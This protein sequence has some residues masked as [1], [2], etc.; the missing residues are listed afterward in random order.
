[1]GLANVD[2]AFVTEAG[3]IAA[4][5]CVFSGVPE[6]AQMPGAKAAAYTAAYKKAFKTNPG[7]WGIFTYD[8]ANL[9]FSKIAATGS[10]SFAPV[11]KALDHTKNYQGATG[12][13]SIRPSTGNRIKVP[14]YIMKVDSKGVF[15][16]VS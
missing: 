8:S 7:V 10:T 2:A 13:I 1:M 14:V 12:N 5:R 9:L 16:V 15:T 6:A 11:L 3:Q 4:E